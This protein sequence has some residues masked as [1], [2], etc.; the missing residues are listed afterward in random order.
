MGASKRP[1]PAV[2]LIITPGFVES[3]RGEDTVDK[4]RVPTPG[5]GASRTEGVPVR[6]RP[7]YDL[8]PI[9]CTYRAEMRLPSAF[10]RQFDM[11]TLTIWTARAAVTV[12]RVSTVSI[13]VS[14]DRSAMGTE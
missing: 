7:F 9:A 4:M 13:L 2:A 6:L 1:R 10:R 12:I 14:I 11:F 8:E 3:L 5:A